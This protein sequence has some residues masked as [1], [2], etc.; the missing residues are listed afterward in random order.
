MARSSSIQRFADLLIGVPLLLALRLVRRRRGLPASPKRIGVICPTAIGDLILASG[1]F[2]RI[3]ERFPD[4]QIHL[5]HGKSNAGALPLLPFDLVAHECDFRALP[6]VVRCARDLGLDVVIDITPWPRFTAIVAGLSRAV[7]VGYRTKWQ[8]RH[9]SFDVVVPHLGNRHEIDNLSAI[10]DVVAGGSDYQTVVRERVERLETEVAWNQM[11]LCH[12]CPGG[13]R[14]SEKR[15]PNERWATLTD[16]LVSMGYRVGFTG[17]LVDREVV[18]DIVS[19][20]SCNRESVM[21]LCGKFSLEELCCAL[22]SCRLFVT[23]DTG[24]MHLA[25]VMGVPTVALMGP[26]SFRRWGARSKDCTV[27]QSSHPRAGY[28]SLGFER[29]SGAKDI[30]E[31]IGVEEVI[32]AVLA[33]L[34]VAGQERFAES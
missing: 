27:I 4:A 15:W 17:G 33:K 6:Q 21:S 5:F 28:I 13:S 9:F 30:M 1:L 14:A 29:C 18:E 3:H 16:R 8:F 22:R 24:V 26:T 34:G 25:S 23:V 20:V 31:R 32:E 2:V 7:A 11:I 10:A 12:P 19:R